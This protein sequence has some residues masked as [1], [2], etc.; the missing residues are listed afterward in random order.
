M[1]ATRYIVYTDL[2]GSL[3]DHHSYDFS[4]AVPALAALRTHDIP[5]IPVSSKTRAEIEPLSESLRLN[6]PFIVENGAAVF[7]PKTADYAYFDTL[8]LTQ[9]EH[10]Y[11]KAF[12]PSIHYWAIVF[13]ELSNVLPNAF[14]PFS[15]LSTA[16]LVKIT[17]LNAKQAELAKQREFSDPLYWFGNDAQFAQLTRFCQNKHIEIVQGGRFVHLLKGS[18]KGESVAWLHQQL[19][20]QENATLCSIGLG[21]GENDIAMLKVVDWPVQI[22]SPTHNFPIFDHPLCLRTENVGPAGWNEAMFKLIPA[23][24]S[25]L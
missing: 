4:L 20:A 11:V 21:D 7:I 10:H 8:K 25:S 19:Q 15:Q 16:E 13:K 2:D 3:I 9:Q 17:G 18:N 6:T 24:N 23:L 5:V 12:A 14:T 1:N 22:K